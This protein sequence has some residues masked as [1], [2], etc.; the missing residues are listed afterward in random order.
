MDSEGGNAESMV[1]RNMI[2][3]YL[4]ESLNSAYLPTLLLGLFVW[5]LL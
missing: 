2:G 5:G 4:P 1:I 3:R